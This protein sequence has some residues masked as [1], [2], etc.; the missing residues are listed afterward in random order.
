M[1]EISKY[2]GYKKKLQGICDENNLTFRFINNHY[3]ITL[4]IR[5]VTGLGEQ[6]SLLESAEDDYISPDACIVFSFVDGAVFYKTYGRFPIS[7]TLFNKIKNLFKNMHTCWLQYFFRSAIQNGALKSGAMPVIDEAE[8]KD[9]EPAPEEVPG[10]DE[11]PDRIITPDEY[12][13]K[14]ATALVRAEN[15]ATTALLQRRLKIGYSRATRLMEEL[16]RIGVVG[17]YNGPDSR[18]VLPSDLPDDE[19]GAVPEAIKTEE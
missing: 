19:E 6:M 9:I 11:T 1:S 8:A 2:E 5:P 3:P 12:L 4:T 7:E 15:K 10:D 13:I 18:E 14:E 17:P 16:E